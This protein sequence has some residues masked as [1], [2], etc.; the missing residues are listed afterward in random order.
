MKK[1]QLVSAMTFA[2][3]A[4]ALSN[5]TNA[6]VVGASSNTS[7]VQIAAS[8]VNGGPHTSGLAGISIEATGLGTEVDFQGL[9]A[10]SPADANGVNQLNYAYDSE[11][12]PATHASLGVFNFAQVGTSDVWFGEWSKT[13]DTTA[14]SHTVYYSGANADTS[15]PTAGTATYTVVGINNYDGTAASL[16]NGTLT[17]D[18]AAATLTGSMANTNGLTVDIGTA[19][20]NSD[21]SVTGSD[22]T[23]SISVIEVASA[24]DVSAQFYNGQADL[25][26]LVDFA[27]TEYDTAFGGSKD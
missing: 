17:A 10:Y 24:G 21:A 6:A 23:A 22:A 19:T 2:F 25:A 13:G 7:Y 11:E 20:I 26:G 5:A 15:V 12:A 27:G 14:A 3:G 18:F 9:T 16:L 4:L 8:E 1:L